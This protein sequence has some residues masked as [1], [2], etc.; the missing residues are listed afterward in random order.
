MVQSPEAGIIWRRGHAHVW[1]LPPAGSFGVA[2]TRALGTTVSSV[3]VGLPH[4]LVAGFPARV[5]RERQENLYQY[6]D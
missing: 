4:N 1:H 5:S 6:Y 2:V 3:A